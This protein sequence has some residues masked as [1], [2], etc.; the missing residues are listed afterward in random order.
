[1]TPEASVGT[2]SPRLDASR[3]RRE[4]AIRGLTG[5]AFAKRAR[6]A[7]ATLSH[8]M[9]GRAITP[10]TVEKI[11]QTLARIQ[12]MPGAGD[13]VAHELHASQQR[14]S[15]AGEVSTHDSRGQKQPRR[16]RAR[17]PHK[18]AARPR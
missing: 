17:G 11:V 9:T 6:V 15:N 16:R 13:L 2:S 14:T 8:A 3:L 10:G 1:M 5:K 7:T 4:L 18:S 12:P